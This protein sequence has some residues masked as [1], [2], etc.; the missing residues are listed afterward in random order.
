MKLELLDVLENLERIRG[1]MI[2][3]LY[4]FEHDIENLVKQGAEFDLEDLRENLFIPLRNHIDTFDPNIKSLHS[5]IK[6]FY[7]NVQPLKNK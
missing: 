3:N 5:V 6:S 7:N 1:E 2:I 4:Q